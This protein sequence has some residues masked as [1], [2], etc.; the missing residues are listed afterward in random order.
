MPLPPVIIE[1]EE[2]QQQDVI[3]MAEQ[4]FEMRTVKQLRPNGKGNFLRLPIRQIRTMADDSQYELLQVPLQSQ[5]STHTFLDEEDE[6]TDDNNQIRQPDSLTS[7]SAIS[8]IP[9]QKA[10]Q[11]MGDS[12]T[13][14]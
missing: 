8:P 10:D 1:P 3:S 13:T 2:A 5:P 7:I 6:E 9:H 4:T 11:K 12:K 14:F